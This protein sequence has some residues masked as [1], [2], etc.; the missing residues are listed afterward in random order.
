MRAAVADGTIAPEHDVTPELMQGV[1]LAMRARDEGRPISEMLNQGDLFNSDTSR[2]VT[3]MLT[4]HGNRLAPR[5]RIEANLRSYVGEAMKNVSGDR[6]FGDGAAPVGDV[7]KASQAKAA[8]ESG[9]DPLDEPRRAGLQRPASARSDDG[10]ERG[11]PLPGRQRGVEGSGGNLWRQADRGCHGGVGRSR[12]L[13]DAG[14]GRAR[15]A[16]PERPW[17][18]TRRCRPFASPSGTTRRRCTSCAIMR[19]MICSGR[20]EAP[21]ARSI[22]RSS[23]AGSRSTARLLRA[24]P[25]LGDQFRD[26][27]TATRTLEE[28]SGQRRDLIKAYQKSVFGKLMNASHPDEVNGIVGAALN[29]L[30]RVSVFRRLAK[31]TS[32]DPMASAGL[33]QSVLDHI[34]G[35]SVADIQTSTGP[36]RTIKSNQFRDLVTRTRPA[37]EEVLG[38]RSAGMLQRISESLL[39]A[40][41]AVEQGREEPRRRDALPE[42]RHQASRELAGAHG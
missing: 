35:R 25:E 31:E 1:N 10:C 3:G 5:P 7:L 13:Q 26:A 36:Q 23:S 2:L 4:N 29:R 11:G 22:Q 20:H 32:A 15:P 17:R 6:L 30:D 24:Y 40:S 21:T 14:I 38:S 16:L 9:G 33:Q 34:V 39:R 18:A 19:L 12:Q 37:L 27:A 42:G 41:H 28:A 8:R